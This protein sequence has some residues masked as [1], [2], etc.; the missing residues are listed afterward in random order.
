MADKQNEKV[1]ENTIGVTVV[2][3]I[4]YAVAMLIGTYLCHAYVCDNIFS[5]IATAWILIPGTGT[6]WFP[7][8]AVALGG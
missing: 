6:V 4:I 1:I 7:C 2:I 8:I 3:I 5:S